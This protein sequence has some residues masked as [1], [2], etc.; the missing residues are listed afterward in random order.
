MV[1]KIAVIALVLIVAAPI[2]LGYGLN[3]ETEEYT[4]YEPG[5]AETNVTPLIA[6]SNEYRYVN[7][8]AYS[9]NTQKFITDQP[10]YVKYT[11]ARTSL[12]MQH[13]YT[14]G[15]DGNAFYQLDAFTYLFMFTNA[16]HLTITI[17]VDGAVTVLNDVE[18]V[19]YNTT[20]PGSVPGRL[21]VIFAGDE[22]VFTGNSIA[23]LLS[24]G[25]GYVVGA[26]EQ[27]KL[28]KAW[29][30][31]AAASANG[32]YVDISGGFLIPS[33]WYTTSHTYSLPTFASEEVITLNLESGHDMFIVTHSNVILLENHGVYWD[34]K[35]GSA[36]NIPDFES[37]C[38]LPNYGVGI[39]T[40]Q[41]IMDNYGF[42]INYVGAWPT[43]IGVA[44][45]YR[46]WGPFPAKSTV[47][48]DTPDIYF[49][50]PS[51]QPDSNS[52]IIRVDSAKLRSTT[53]SIIRDHIYDPVNIVEY[54]PQTTINGIYETGTS[55][56]FGGNTYPASNGNITIGTH[57]VS[58]QKCV[59]DSV[60]NGT[61]YDNRING[62]VVSTTSWPSTITFNGK[63]GI[64]SI[65][66]VPLVATPQTVQ[67]WIPGEFAWDGLDTNFKMAGLVASLGAFVGLAIYGRRS[68]AKVLPLMLVCGG[69]AF[70]FLLMI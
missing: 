28:P 1:S 29:D 15:W 56:S 64:A 53:Y 44:N 36:I 69:A 48:G 38:W 33:Y 42:S 7:A 22:R 16:Q 27:Y 39:S 60:P 45:S 62:Y 24:P 61:G 5:A 20:T 58:L 31:P 50:F 18:V 25:P 67:K 65:T 46:S 52:P 70:V 8:D 9:I 35:T 26:L 47:G 59:F 21:S 6:L 55:I 4:S 37:V 40:Y 41:F 3:I 49:R 19:D 11:H 14:G 68:G 17:N 10:L 30:N 32:I 34:V 57:Q 51:G 63:W 66:S 12:Y 54:N 2:L 23:I 13:D 43:D